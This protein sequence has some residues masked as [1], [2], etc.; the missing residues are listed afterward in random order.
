[1]AQRSI[2]GPGS[3]FA[4]G[5]PDTVYARVTSYWPAQISIDAPAT[6]A[7]TNASNVQ[8]YGLI[9][10]YVGLLAAIC[11]YQLAQYALVR[12]VDSLFYAAYLIVLIVDA[13]NLASR[14][15]SLSKE[16]RVRI[17]IADDTRAALRSPETWNLRYLGRVAVKG[18][19]EAIGMYE[20]LAVEDPPTLVRWLAMLP[21]F[22]QGVT[23]L[24]EHAHADAA[25]L[26]ERCWPPTRATGRPTCSVAAVE[27]FCSLPRCPV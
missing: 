8:R 12:N 24:E 9:F 26:F 13:V 25:V 20:V 2:K 14:I 18:K 1:M 16:M 7:A 6:F 23:A 5:A 11:V 19:A 22:E 10:F 3:A 21:T 17:L 27:P 4:L 15:E